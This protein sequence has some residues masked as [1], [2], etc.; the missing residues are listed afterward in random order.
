M[1]FS[2][3]RPLQSSAVMSRYRK[4]STPRLL[5]E[6][7]PALGNVLYVPMHDPVRSDD[8]LPSGLLAGSLSLAP[9]LQVRAL[10]AVSMIDVEG[11][12]EWIECLDGSGRP[13]VRLYL[14]PDTDY[15]AWDAMLDCGQP[16]P[17]ASLPSRHSI[18]CNA[19]ATMLRFRWRRLAGLRLLQA[20]TAAQASELSR[21]LAEQ[22]THF[23][24]TLERH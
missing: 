2:L 24:F 16:A 18:P 14:L 9:L 3:L 11:P 20:E 12:R 5:A 7:L 23:R 13:R 22:M 19:E 1:H 21:Q 4:L 15:C 10:L 17:L 8:K 6:R